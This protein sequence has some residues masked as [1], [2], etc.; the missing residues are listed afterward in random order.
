M[1]VVAPYCQYKKTN[2]KIYI[3]MLLAFAVYFA[4]DGYLNTTRRYVLSANI[5][6]MGNP[7]Q[8]LFLTE[9]LRFFCWQEQWLLRFGTGK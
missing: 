2:F 9:S 7:T 8:H 5:C 6:M 4:Y 3:V 1:A